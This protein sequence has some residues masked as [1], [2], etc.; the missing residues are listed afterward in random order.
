MVVLSKC[1]SHE[2]DIAHDHAHEAMT[3]T[4]LH[5]TVLGLDV[6]IHTLSVIN[7]NALSIIKLPLLVFRVK[8]FTNSKLK[9][10]CN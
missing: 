8:P 7:V 2:V 10:C 6:H 3:S 4:M 5:P 1:I 9:E